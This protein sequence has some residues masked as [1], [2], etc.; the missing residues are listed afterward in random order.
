MYDMVNLKENFIIY[1]SA[2]IW[3]IPVTVFSLL[4]SILLVGVD[5]LEVLSL[6]N[7]L[8]EEVI[9]QG[10]TIT[11]EDA[12]PFFIKSFLIKLGVS[13]ISILPLIIFAFLGLKRISRK[14]PD[15]MS[16]YL[17]KLEFVGAVFIWSIFLG[18]IVLSLYS[19]EFVLMPFGLLHLI[20]IFLVIQFFKTPKKL[21]N[22][23]ENLLNN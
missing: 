18:S 15:L 21:F 3:A 17:G 10:K 2:F 23:T 6:Q 22:T 7:F 14:Y 8:H 16:A 19:R 1:K 12:D 20:A 5:S 9:E 13:L 4:S 11:S